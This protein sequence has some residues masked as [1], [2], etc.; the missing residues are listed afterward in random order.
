VAPDG[1]PFFLGK[2]NGLLQDIVSHAELS[3]VVQ[4]RPVHEPLK[5]FFVEAKIFPDKQR[6]AGDLGSVLGG[7]AVLGGGGIDQD[8]GGIAGL[9]PSRGWV[10]LFYASGLERAKKGDGCLPLYFRV[11]TN[12]ILSPTRM[13]P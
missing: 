1:L 13:V 5:P 2:G 12:Q 4:E 8:R 10:R 9:F 7:V 6:E 11:P 3:E